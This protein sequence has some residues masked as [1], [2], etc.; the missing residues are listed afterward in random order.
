MT[1]YQDNPDGTRDYI[2]DMDAL[3][4]AAFLDDD[5]APELTDEQF[6]RLTAE[7]RQVREENEQTDKG[8][9]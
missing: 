7:M 5:D 3:E 8:S 9:A 6:E 2:V 1:T 4:A